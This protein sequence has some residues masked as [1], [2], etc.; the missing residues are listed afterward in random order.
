M[1]SMYSMTVLMIG[2]VVVIVVV[3]GLLLALRVYGARQV[4]GDHP[5][6]P[7]D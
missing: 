4:G 7:R 6:R 3:G 5:T 1:M 2:L